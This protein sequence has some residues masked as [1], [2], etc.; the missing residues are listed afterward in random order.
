MVRIMPA[1]KS[2]D[3]TAVPA[4]ASS[5][6]FASRRFLA[7]RLWKDWLVQHAVAV[8]GTSVIIIITLIF[9]YLLWVV[10]PMFAPAQVEAV[11][12][13]AVP[14]GDPEWTVQLGM[15]E[16]AEI[17]MRVSEDARVVFFSTHDGQIVET[18]QFDLPVGT[19]VTSF[20]NAAPTKAAMALGL[21]NGSAIVVERKYEVSFPEEGRR[22]ITPVLAFPLG[23]DPIPV[24]TD[25]QALETLALQVGAERMTLAAPVSAGELL[26]VSFTKEESFLG[27]EEEFVRKQHTMPGLGEPVAHILIDQDQQELYVASESGTLNYYDINDPDSPEL[28]QRLSLL[29]TEDA[30]LTSLQ[31]LTGGISLLMG[32][33]L[34]NLVQWFPVRDA[35]GN[36]VMTRIREFEPLPAAITAI[37][38]EHSRKG[39]LATDA[40]G[41]LG[42]YHTTAHRTVLMEP[43][44]DT[45]VNMLAIG[46]RANALLAQD[47]K[48]Q[49]YFKN[50][51]NEHPEISWSGLW[52]KVWYESYDEPKYLWQS[53]AATSDFEPKFS[54]VPISFGT[55]KAAFYAMV[56]AVPLSIMGAIFTAHFMAP[57]MRRVVKPS[58]EIMEALPTVILGFLAGLWLAPFIEDYLPGIFSLLLIMPF[59]I[60]LAAYIWHRMPDSV[61]FIVPDG[62]EGALLI[63]VVIL[64]GYV[65]LSLS[66]TLE[67]I[68]FGGDMRRWLTNEMGINFD[69]RNSIVVGLAMGFAVIPTIFSIAEDAIFAV[70]KHLVQGS[71][72]LGATPWQTMMRVVLLTASPGIFSA[73][74]IGFGRAV[75]ETMI[76]LMATGNTPVMDMS[77][78]Q[79]MRT[80]S[81]NIAVEMPES[82]VDSTHYRVLFL[83]ALVL[84]A[85]T[86]LFNTIAEVVRQRLRRRYSSL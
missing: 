9:F 70:P 37:A 58:I 41:N 34:G 57:R 16:Q 45:A 3:V 30:R 22:V 64:I 76:V 66:P 60:L 79:G 12:E 10:L 8:G 29:E 28:I 27:E 21:S 53:S 82:E 40:D 47:A 52:G 17:G 13:Y 26:V 78:F 56:I 42:I 2:T 49:I 23:S 1:M 44:A 81:A 63:P 86:F 61:R 11:A 71:L 43:L 84:F 54:L 69:Q 83:A 15:E 46:P 7:W 77:I 48:G 4:D 38:P 68:F 67:S 51:H 50:I 31:T 18:Q 25:G 74:M 85:F 6:R 80:L 36:P 72:A 39:F 24:R 19:Q 33:S 75:G 35:A 65:S 59:G 73:V 62:W 14:G 5:G 55:L 20:A 32:D